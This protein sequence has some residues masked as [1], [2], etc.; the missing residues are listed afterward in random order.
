MADYLV[1]YL[2]K[3]RVPTEAPELQAAL[4]ANHYKLSLAECGWIQSAVKGLLSRIDSKASLNFLKGQNYDFKH[5]AS[6]GIFSCAKLLHEY[7]LAKREE[8]RLGVDNQYLHLF[9]VLDAGACHL[10][11]TAIDKLLDSVFDEMHDPKSPICEYSSA[12]T[13]TS[14]EQLKISDDPIM[15]A[16]GEGDSTDYQLHAMNSLYSLCRSVKDDEFIL[17]DSSEFVPVVPL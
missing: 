1:F 13:P 11:A 7:R 5:I 12:R 17:V 16:A 2:F 9:W 8:W 10:A 4:S 15:L 3:E 14:R 6:N